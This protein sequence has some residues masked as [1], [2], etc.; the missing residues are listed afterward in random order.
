MI[1]LTGES[2]L[3]LLFCIFSLLYLAL[4]FSLTLGFF[5]KYVIS[6]SEW[7]WFF[8]TFFFL[9]SF[10]SLFLFALSLSLYF[11][12]FSWDFILSNEYFPLYEWI[13]N[14]CSFSLERKEKRGKNEKEKERKRR[15]KR[16]FFD[17]CSFIMI[18]NWKKFFQLFSWFSSFSSNFFFNF[19][20]RKKKK[21]RRKEKR[22]KNFLETKN[23]VFFL[24]FLLV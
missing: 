15:Q 20:S 18:M 23:E 8:F 21:E 11:F 12:F 7:I 1:S 17:S 3:S 13:M 19:L 6:S 24:S 14:V 9:P 4:H 10:L 2:T 22:G 5:V 16:K